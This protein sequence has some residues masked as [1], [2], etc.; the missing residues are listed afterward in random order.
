M[1][2]NEWGTSTSA[3]NI[4]IHGKKYI[5]KRKEKEGPL[6]PNMEFRIEINTE[7]SQVKK[8]ISTCQLKAGHNYNKPITSFKHSENFLYLVK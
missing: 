6:T 2:V 8:V 5:Y 3:P 4:S 7:R 1:T